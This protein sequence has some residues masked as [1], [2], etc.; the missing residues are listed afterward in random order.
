MSALGV[1]GT[2]QF[3][4]LGPASGNCVLAAVTSGLDPAVYFVKYQLPICIPVIL[5][6]AVTHY[7][8]QKWWDKRE[9]YDLKASQAAEAITEEERPPLIYAILPTVPLIL[10]VGFS[11]IFNNPITLNVITAMIMSTLLSIL[12]EYIRLKD[13]R[14]VLDSLLVFFDGMGKQLTFVVSLIIAGEVFATGLLKIGA[15]DTLIDGAKSAGFGVK[16]MIIAM[17]LLIGGSALLMGSGNAAF[18]SFAS[19]APKVAAHLNV[20]TVT[21]LLPMQI[22]TSFGR[23]VSPITAAIVAIAGIGGVSPFQIVKRTAIP[24]AVAAVLNIVV[25]FIIFVP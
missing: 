25:D 3:I 7:F 14:P 23:T 16:F 22:M 11:P 12:F 4:D 5:G 19:L 17:S 15:V 13:A 1:I 6:V 20:E 9:G 2:C 24:M 10:V 8:V 18:F 21:L